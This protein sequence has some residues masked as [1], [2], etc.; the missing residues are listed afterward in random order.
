MMMYQEKPGANPEDGITAESKL[1]SLVDPT[2]LI[3]QYKSEL[4][5]SIGLSA[6]IKQ[7]TEL[8]K[9]FA[10]VANQMGRGVQISEAIQK[11][12]AEA[13]EN[14]IKL[15]GSTSD[16]V[17][18]QEG[19]LS[20][21]NKNIIASSDVY[22]K[23]FATTK[24][25]G[26]ATDELAT[27]F[28]DAGMS[29]SHITEEMNSVVNI[30][31]SL[32]VNAKTVSSLVVSNL[33]KLNRYGFDK[34]IEGLAKMA[35]QA[36]AL[37]VNMQSTFTLA[38]DLL[39]PEKAIELASTIQRFGVV[40]GDL[41]DPLKLMDLAQNNVPELQNQL[42]KLFKE[43]IRFNEDTQSFQLLEGA[44]RDL[45]DIAAG[46]GFTFEEAMKFGV[47]VSDLE[48]KLSEIS[49][50][51][52]KIDEDTKQAVAN[53]ATLNK[54]TGTYE[55]V[56]KD[57][58]AVELS[59]FIE[60]YTGKESE[61]QE[62]IKGKEI[63]TTKTAEQEMIDTAKGQ[64]GKLGE[65]QVALNEMTSFLKVSIAK[66][67]EGRKLLS[68]AEANIKSGTKTVLEE[69]KKV[70]VKDATEGLNKILLGEGTLEDYKKMF[71]TAYDLL[72]SQVTG[73]SSALYE[74][75]KK[76]I[77]KE[78][79]EILGV[80]ESGTNTNT[81]TQT[82]VELPKPVELPEPVELPG[83]TSQ[84][85]LNFTEPIDYTKLNFG[86]N[87]AELTTNINDQNATIGNLDQTLN[88]LMSNNFNQ[89]IEV[90]LSDLTVLQTEQNN[91][92]EK[93]YN[94]LTEIKNLLSQ[95][96]TITIP[97]EN[98]LPT[99]IENLNFD[100]TNRELVNLSTA[101]G[102]GFAQ[103]QT[104]P[105]K[106]VEN[107]IIPQTNEKIIQKEVTPIS[108]NEQV[109]IDQNMIKDLALMYNNK[110]LNA[111][112]VEENEKIQTNDNDEL[113]KSLELL[114]ETLKEFKIQIPKIEI[115]DNSQNNTALNT[116]NNFK[117]ITNTI[118]EPQPKLVTEN[119]ET[120]LEIPNFNLND[121]LNPLSDVFN[122][123]S[124]FNTPQILIPE[125][126]IA[127]TQIEQTPIPLSPE[128]KAPVNLLQE[129]TA[130]N[131]TKKGVVDELNINQKLNIVLEV[132]GN[133]NRDLAEKMV[134]SLRQNPREL[135]KLI[136]EI[137]IKNTEYG[138]NVNS[139]MSYDIQLKSS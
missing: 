122:N 68:S 5:A 94:E 71:G 42:G 137:K 105:K 136:R 75:I 98:T 81:N 62:F 103:L 41:I 26:I 131:E 48:K 85:N 139:K 77:P 106:N 115:P 18:I 35:S 99:K 121:L 30:A 88:N 17:K 25:T 23:L 91:I 69:V 54:N 38:E 1:I 44:K 119:K 100:E 49:F 112:P 9:G 6:V 2:Q 83:P 14:V 63:D 47:G 60:S 86:D 22:D 101:L 123:I 97:N 46:F 19:L 90:D 73:Q 110:N 11:N 64:L 32:G 107:E 37:R 58:S 21:T 65:I 104:I 12:F 113:S 116:L 56:N 53:M 27:G 33:D 108:V 133:Q 29:L 117:G 57:G 135:E 45:T 126:K 16:V 28:L 15:G 84:N 118:E 102:I 72:T 50:G 134:E 55:I 67:P 125:Q 92:L 4:D 34:G 59:K 132:G 138:A 13:T 61:L 124:Q 76:S 89:N 7:L 10:S 78:L 128:P 96:P 36:S 87:V 93:N 120:P 114:G 82:P 79:K 20:A 3:T 129:Q 66:T 40:S 39:S 31:T 130:Q 80:T 109:N 70:D 24:V 95:Q 8:D 74:Q 52:L 127:T 51:N 43:F 111:N